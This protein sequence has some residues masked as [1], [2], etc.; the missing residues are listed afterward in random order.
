MN[1]EDVQQR[2]R[3]HY[4]THAKYTLTKRQRA[5]GPAAPLKKY[6]NAIKRQ[7]IYTFARNTPSL[8]DVA[9]GRGGDLSK[10]EC[11]GVRRVLGIDLSEGEIQEATRRSKD[12][13][14]SC[15]FRVVETLATE[16]WTFGVFDRITCMFAVQYFCASES[17]LDHF[18][19]NVSA[20]LKPGGFF[21]G[22]VPDGMMVQKAYREGN[23]PMLRIQPLWTGPCKP[24]GTAYICEIADTVTHGG[25]LEY[26]VDEDAFLRVAQKHDLV[27]VT[28]Y[29]NK[30][31]HT[32]LHSYFPHSL[33]K[34]FKP[35]F[36]DESLTRASSL[37][38]TFVF[39][40]KSKKLGQ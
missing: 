6:H 23:T 27:P 12:F 21:F 24:F 5:E 11:A 28:T 26:L 9:C 36:D 17:M 34:H 16:D 3:R 22:T 39:Q 14:L 30:D 37:F 38:A 31:L 18:L 25:S 40:K 32:H 2:I 15:E 10:W 19:R 7:L 13:T 35:T 33:F 20:S 29:P 1:S 8:L 4:D